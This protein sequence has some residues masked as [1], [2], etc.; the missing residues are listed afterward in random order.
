MMQQQ[1]AYRPTVMGQKHSVEQTLERLMNSVKKMEADNNKLSTEMTRQKRRNQVLTKANENNDIKIS[2]IVGAA[3]RLW[4]KFLDQESCFKATLGDAYRSTQHFRMIF[5]KL[6]QQQEV[7]QE[8]LKK[9]LRDFRFRSEKSEKAFE[10]AK[11]MIEG[12]EKEILR[13]T[14]TLACQTALADEDKRKRIQEK[15]E[16]DKASRLQ[17]DEWDTRFDTTVTTFKEESA[18]VNTRH[19]DM[20]SKLEKEHAIEIQTLNDKL[21]EKQDTL[22]STKEQLND[23]QKLYEESCRKE[24][25]L[26]LKYEK[27]D[28]TL[29]EEMNNVTTLFENELESRDTQIEDLQKSSNLITVQLESMQKLLQN[30]ATKE[31]ESQEKIATMDLSLQNAAI[32]E[33][34]YRDLIA[35]KKD[36]FE[37]EYHVKST[38]FSSLIATKERDHNQALE[39]IQSQLDKAKAIE[40]EL[41]GA[42]AKSEDAIAVLKIDH[43]DIVQKMQTRL[44]DF[45]ENETQEKEKLTDQKKEIEDLQKKL[46]EMTTMQHTKGQE[47]A[48]NDYNIALDKLQGEHEAAM[49]ILR[50]EHA[51]LNKK[52]ST[53]D[54]EFQSVKEKLESESTKTQ[55]LMNKLTADHDSKITKK[56][57]ELVKLQTKHAEALY[58]IEA[59]QKKTAQSLL[60]EQRKVNNEE[61]ELL[62]PSVVPETFEQLPPTPVS[63]KKKKSTPSAKRANVTPLRTPYKARGVTPNK[64]TPKVKKTPSRK[65]NAFS[66][67]PTGKISTMKRKADGTK[68][69]RSRSELAAE[70]DPFAYTDD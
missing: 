35:T 66:I 24:S 53:A 59:A 46:K 8:K 36:E 63:G 47:S 20:V 52:Y 22:I 38:E 5:L 28:S 12:Q 25:E 26:T 23:C 29:R 4:Q 32:K 43:N 61:S 30:S 15:E 54:K 50:A 14:E 19:A 33:K 6:K 27:N 42:Q 70:M 1:M 68:R 18:K 39:N 7:A 62:L 34:Q 57:Q 48:K 41:K 55:A 40:K 2:D 3:N 69:V 10:T 9:D 65:M 37:K 16:L 44:A 64:Y 17:K 56:N 45:Q 51:D 58:A 21:A 67:P 13:L 60:I 49:K 11:A 31:I